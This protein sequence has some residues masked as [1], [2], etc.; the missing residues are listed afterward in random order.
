MSDPALDT[1]LLPFATGALTWP[2]AGGMLFLRARMGSAL[3]Q[4][5]VPR[6]RLICRQTFR[7]FANDLE[8]AGV[9][10]AQ[11]PDLPKGSF[12]LILLLP[13][14]Q[15]DEARHL[16]AEAVNHVMAGGIVVAAST[17]NEGARSVEADL[18][19]LAGDVSSLSKNKARVFWNVIDKAHIDQTLLAEWLALGRPRR[20][21]SDPRFLTRPGLFAWDRIDA[22]SALLAEH[23][24]TDI[25]GAGA[26]L[27]CGFGY[28]GAEI[29]AH[30][31]RVKS[32]D[33]YEAERLAL[34]L[35]QGNLAPLAKGVAL[36]FLWQDVTQG[37]QRR[38]DFI[39]SNPPFHTGRADRVDLG[40]GFIVAAAKALRPGGRLLIVANRHLPYEEVFATHFAHRRIVTI[41]DGY[42]IIEGTT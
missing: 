35:A 1:L 38:Y 16:L 5:G 26:D 9:A 14:R 23:L 30:C 39:V 31:P 10:L 40:Q 37:L 20:L 15:R 7:P 32:L 25:S 18:G 36:D 22:G 3:A 4:P 29:L 41:A 17:N 12:P 19:K 42:K 34:D 8:A 33:C 11:D 13:P 27:G 28:L 2:T 6:D 24:P 21:E